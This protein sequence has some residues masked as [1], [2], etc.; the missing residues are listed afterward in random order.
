MIQFFQE[1][2]NRHYKWVLRLMDD[3][4]V[5]MENYHHLVSQL[6]SSRPII[7]GEKYCHPSFSYPTGGPGF[8]LSRGFIDNFNFGSWKSIT[9][10][11][12]KEG[13]YD[14]LVWGQQVREM[15]AEFIHHSGF[16]QLAA[17]PTNNMFQ[18]IASR[19]SWDLPFRPIAYHQGPNRFEY[20]GP[21]DNILHRV[22]Y[23]IPDKK[24]VT[25]PEC[26]CWPMSQEDHEIRCTA[27][28]ALKPRKKCGDGLKNIKCLTG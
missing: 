7:I 3:T 17:G 24:L 15:K 18:Y 16:S 11:R 1:P 14:D 25:A 19:S 22:P 28:E 26:Q 27:S 2:H 12:N 20:M 13:I 9:S 4:Y 10:N 5:H 8:I 21:L 23:H 6:D